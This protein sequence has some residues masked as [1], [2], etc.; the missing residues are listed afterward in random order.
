MN[1]AEDVLVIHRLWVQRAI[2]ALAVREHQFRLECARAEPNAIVQ[3]AL[4]D[5]MLIRG[6]ALAEFLTSGSKGDKIHRW[7]FLPGWEPSDSREKQ[8]LVEL[9]RFVSEHL[10]HLLVDPGG[11]LYRIGFLDDILAV[12]GE[13][14]TALRYAGADQDAEAFDAQLAMAREVQASPLQE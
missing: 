4:F 14:A 3:S 11:Y 2:V 13:F 6:R 9:R 1:A 5:S 12:F 8:R 10:A 7:E